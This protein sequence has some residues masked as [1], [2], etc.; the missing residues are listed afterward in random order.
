MNLSAN[1]HCCEEMTDRVNYRR[2]EHP[3]VCDCADNLISY[4]PELNEYGLI[5]HDGGSS[6]IQI[7][8]CPWCG[9]KL[10]ESKRDQ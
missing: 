4:S 9:S 6:S 5:V 2:P 3:D 10:P 1:T 7:N 8:F